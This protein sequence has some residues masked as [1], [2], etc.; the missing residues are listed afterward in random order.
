[1]NDAVCNVRRFAWLWLL[2]ILF[3][4]GGALYKG[5]AFDSSV[6][7]LLPESK[8][9]YQ[10]RSLLD[11][12]T[13]DFSDRIL[14]VLS[15][16]DK[17]QARD[18][19]ALAA[20][21]LE[22]LAADADI[23][24]R[25]E[26]PA[27]VAEAL[28]PYRFI[29]L[30]EKI[31]QR[32]TADKNDLQY[33][34]AL[35]RFFT[36]LTGGRSDPVGDPFTL[37]TD[38]MLGWQPGLKVSIE[39]GLFR[40]TASPRPA[41]LLTVKLRGDP[42]ALPLQK[43]VLA[44]TG[45]L[46]QELN[47][48][49]VEMKR[50]GLLWHAAAGAR[51]AE[52]EMSTIGFGSLVGITLLILMV[53]RSLMPLWI[54]LLPVTVGCLMALAVCLLFF[55]RVHLITLAFGA[56]LV[57]VAVDY[58]MHFICEY[59][60]HQGA[61]LPRTLY[62]GLLMGLVSSLIAYAGL[63]LAPFPGLRQMAVFSVTGLAAAWLTVV[64]WLPVFTGRSRVVPLGAAQRLQRWR[65]LYP[66]LD[67][68]PALKLVLAL[69]GLVSVLVITQGEARD[70][71]R[72]LQT[73][74]AE[75]LEEDSQVQQLIG[76]TSS[77]QFLLVTADSVESVLRIEER[78]RESLER[79]HGE[80]LLA[81]YQALSQSLPSQ[82]R[83][84]ESAALVTQLYDRQLPELSALLHFSEQQYHSARSAME[85]GTVQRLDLDEWQKLPFA[86]PW[87]QLLMSREQGAVATV[88][89]LQG[90]PGAALRQ[91]LVELAETTEGVFFVDRIDAMSAVLADYREQIAGWL[92]IAYG[93]VVL[94][95]GWR[96]RWD[97]WRIIFPPL[98][99]SLV[100]FAALILS[101]SGYNLF[102]L[103]A[104]MLVLGIGLDMGIFLYESADSDHTWL[105]VTLSALTSLLAFGLLTLSKT[106]VL[107]HFGIVVLP[108]LALAWLIAPLMR[109]TPRGE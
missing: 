59:R 93:L 103:I 17:R 51:Q 63:A 104:L 11:R 96:Y 42:F 106:P 45:A 60:G 4:I 5:T 20:E 95:L 15:A 97:M 77:A 57:G 71:V 36:P 53:F 94:L 89:R 16:D 80:G 47:A 10:I 13:D 65:D 92:L 12:M 1:M 46:Q 79:M 61:P 27:A 85:R 69:T 58:A 68:R 78:L 37:H 31:R 35:Q 2:V 100:T 84:Q 30:D 66:R 82:H 49:G 107:Y 99:A 25:Q 64:L 98:L 54:A 18:A 48:V 22:S 32:L 76:S 70:S 56:G 105:A 7:A 101:G 24:W 38:L 43:R 74:P 102:N 50:S 33:R 81:G 44:V 67:N 90:T 109:R 23:L 73:S 3:V 86:Q 41:Y 26:T 39:Q 55:G 83:Q 108:G 88:I 52:A 19:V 91:Q 87:H 40:L 8:E 75:L 6:M 9:N 34:L 28:Y 14:F 29:L 62:T 21:R 72:L